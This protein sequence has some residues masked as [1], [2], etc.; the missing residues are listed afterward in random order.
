MIVDEVQTGMG[1]TGSLLAC[2]NEQVKPDILLLGKALSGGMMPVSAVLADNHI[3]DVI[4]PGTHGSTF[5]GNPLGCALVNKAINLLT[6]EKMI[7]N[8]LYQGIYLKRN[9]EDIAKENDIIVKVRGK[10]LMIGLEIINNKIAEDIVNELAENGILC[11]L[12]RGNII[13]LSPPLIITRDDIN[14]FLNKLLII[15]N[16]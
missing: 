12:T 7:E 3:M 2:D 10:G 8:S 1:R 15:L 13:R 11:K 6:D 5:G 14:T 9:L 4:T 16:K